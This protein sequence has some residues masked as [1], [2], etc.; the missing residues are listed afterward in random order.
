M[1]Y[2]IN[3]KQELEEFVT[4]N[5]EKSNDFLCNFSKDLPIPFYTSV[6]IRESD[7][8]FAPVDNNLYPAG[9]NNICHLD[10]MVCRDRLKN[11]ITHYQKDARRIGIIPESNTKNKFYLD[12]L[13]TLKSLIESNDNECIIVSFDKELFEEKKKLELTSQSE[14]NL[15]I[16]PGQIIENKI[17]V[18]DRPFD[19]IILNHDQS[20]PMGLNW[21][22]ITTKIAPSP[23][24]GWFHRKKTS[25]FFFYK[26]VADIFCKEF[27]INPDLIQANFRVATEIDFL[28]KEGLEELSSKVR[29]LQNQI[30]EGK[31]IFIKAN[32]GT[33]GMG[34]MTVSSPEEVLEINRKIRNKMDIGKNK[35]KFTSVIVQEGIETA[36][37]HNGNPAEITIYLVGGKSTGGFMRTNP[38]KDANSNL[39]SRGMVYQKFC[40]S[41]IHQ[42][43]DHKAKEA[44]YSI[45]ARI[46][47]IAAAYEINETLENL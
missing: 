22:A 10:Q 27:S 9:F 8:K 45:I 38:L 1:N 23:H 28:Q 2:Q 14:F 19:F 32:Q 26:E 34:I 13:Y 18:N 37:T 29:D 20:S 31:T 30:G 21:S 25:H 46:S 35:I 5:W 39:N 36:I 33:Y 6:D 4:H 16:F 3:T 42:G 40:M 12:H 43:H 11:E 41:E 47:T 24:M 44:V 17:C 15:E 7:K